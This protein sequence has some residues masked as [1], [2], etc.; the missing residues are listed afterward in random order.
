MFFTRWNRLSVPSNAGF[1]TNHG[2]PAIAIEVS[3]VFCCSP[4][5]PTHRRIFAAII[6]FD[7]VVASREG[8]VEIIELLLR[9]NANPMLAN[10]FGETAVTVAKTPKIET[11]PNSFVRARAQVSSCLEKTASTIGAQTRTQTS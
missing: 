10:N 2:L 1:D 7:G 8:H 4:R 5:V 11:G 9:N 6:Q 3:H